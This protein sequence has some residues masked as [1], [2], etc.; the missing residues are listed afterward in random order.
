[1]GASSFDKH[2]YKEEEEMR[3]RK[4]RRSVEKEEVYVKD[5]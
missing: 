2:R 5:E 1:V 3:K 4:E